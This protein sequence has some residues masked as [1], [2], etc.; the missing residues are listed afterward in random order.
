MCTIKIIHSQYCI[1]VLGIYK[2][3]RCFY[4][5][6]QRERNKEFSLYLTCSDI[7][8]RM[9]IL[10]SKWLP[11]V[12]GGHVGVESTA[13]SLYGQVCYLWLPQE[14]LP[15]GSAAVACRKIQCNRRR[16]RS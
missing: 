6:S 12:T 7:A 15:I 4:Y 10:L 8:E 16:K 14:I 9:S 2:E 5:E 11:V 13:H 1:N 3:K